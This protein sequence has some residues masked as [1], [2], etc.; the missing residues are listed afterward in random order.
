MRKQQKRQEMQ[1]QMTWRRTKQRKADSNFNKRAVKDDLVSVTVCLASL[2]QCMQILQPE[3]SF[4]PPNSMPRHLQPASLSLS[5]RQSSSLDIGETAEMD[6]FGITH[7][8]KGSYMPKY[9]PQ[10]VPTCD[11]IRTQNDR[12]LL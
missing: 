10:I 9:K 1:S 12:M 3:H 2:R 6:R 5:S 7:V 4:F 11:S 8:E